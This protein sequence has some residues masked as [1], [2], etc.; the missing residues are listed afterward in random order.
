M[1]RGGGNRGGKGGS[2][3]PTPAQRGQ[4]RG[5]V[6]NFFTVARLSKPVSAAAFCFLPFAC[7][8][9]SRVH[10]AGVLHQK[11]L[12]DSRQQSVGWQ[13]KCGPDEMVPRSPAGLLLLLRF[14]PSKWREKGR[15]HHPGQARGRREVPDELGSFYKGI[16]GTL[17]SLHCCCSNCIVV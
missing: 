15:L 2:R 9:Y 17:L 16:P 10:G 8:R 11:G 12:L 7:D 1:P 6:Q 5:G 13:S 14:W 4:I 3:A